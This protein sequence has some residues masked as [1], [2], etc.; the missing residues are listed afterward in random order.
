M[1]GTGRDS[2]REEGVRVARV[3]VRVRSGV[4]YG[5]G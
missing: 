4:C 1:R 3:S 5:Y 2:S